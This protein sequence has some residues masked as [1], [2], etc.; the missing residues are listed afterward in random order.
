MDRVVDVLAITSVRANVTIESLGD[1][2]SFAASAAAS[3]GVSVEDTAAAIGVLGDRGIPAS[4][5]GAGLNIV[6]AKMVKFTA[7]A[8]KSIKDMQLKTSDL[9]I[10]IR[11]FIPVIETLAEKN[12]TLRQAI[13]LVG[14]RQAKA[15]LIIVDSVKRMKELTEEY[16][17]A[18]ISADGLSRVMDDNLNGAL[19]RVRSATEGVIIALGDIGTENILRV[20]LEGLVDLLRA[21]ARNIQ[22]VI[23]GFAVLVVGFALTKVTAA[24]NILLAAVIRLNKAI[25]LNPLGAFAT[26]LVADSLC[27]LSLPGC[28]PSTEVLAQVVLSRHL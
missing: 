1:A 25:L 15:L 12:L 27:P 10:E 22:D 28:S 3:L 21:V 5:A 8:R 16:K 19:L 18:T 14:L 2:M 7:A 24:V 20:G 13:D 26:A 11:G 17:N 9:N 6:F 4:R 23:D